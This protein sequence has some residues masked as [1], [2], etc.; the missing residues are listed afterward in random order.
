MFNKMFN[1]NQTNNYNFLN[2]N[3]YKLDY[4]FYQFKNYIYLNLNSIVIISLILLILCLLFKNYKFKFKL[5]T[6]NTLNFINFFDLNNIILFIIIISFNLYIY[7]NIIYNYININLPIIILFLLPT[8]IIPITYFIIFNTSSLI[9]I[10][11]TQKKSII[12]ALVNDYITIISFLLRFFSQFIRI[13][14]IFLVLV[15][16]H[17]FINNNIYLIEITNNSNI[18]KSL[19]NL[20]ITFI[21]IVFELIDC[22]FIFAIQFN[23]FFIIL[24][25]LLSFLFIVK[26]N[27]IFEN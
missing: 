25:W 26:F 14:L 20:N 5:N 12:G 17:E 23:I 21:R 7:Q 10:S 11:L 22:F 6:V 8:I 9:C 1:Y 19:N 15:L 24:L 2:L 4:K 16:L 3:F 27:N 18:I 13:I